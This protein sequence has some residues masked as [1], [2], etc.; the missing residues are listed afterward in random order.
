V[1]RVIYLFDNFQLDTSRRLLLHGEQ[2]LPLTARL[3]DTLIYLVEHAGSVVSKE[4]L[5]KA[6][7]PDA[8]VEENNLTQSIS[9]LRRVL[10]ERKGENRFIVTVAGHGYRFVAIASKRT[11]VAGNTSVSQR[12]IAVLPFKPLV[13]KHQDEALQLGMA[14]ALIIRLSSSREMIVRPLTSVRRFVSLDQDAQAAGRE[15]KVESVLDGNIQRAGDRVRVSARLIDV[16]DG[17]SLWAGTFDE[18]FTDVFSVQDAISERVAEALKLRLT[19]Q[20]RHGLTKRYTQNTAAYEL[21][22]QGRYHWN[23]LIPPEVW[24]AIGYFEQAIALDANYALAYTGM[25]VA[26]ISLPISCDVPPQEAFPRA[27]AAALE[28]LHIDESLHDAYAYLALSTCWFDW[29]SEAAETQIKRGLAI[30]PNSAELHR[31]YGILLSHT[32]RFNDAIAEGVRARELD[33]L[34]LITRVNEALHFYFARDHER[35]LGRI[36]QTLELEPTFWVALLT[37]ARIYVQQ[38]KLD[39][40]VSD[41]SKARDLCVGSTQPLAMLGQVFAL[42]GKRE[43]AKEILKQMHQ[44]ATQRYVPPYN[45]ALVHHGLGDDEQTFIWLERALEA[46]DVLLAA[47]IS[48]EPSWDQLRAERRFRRLLKRMNL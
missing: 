22:L 33:P 24:K 7:W 3:I 20:D 37:R 30:N 15:L 40:A 12:R 39:E 19:E 14:D 28:A 27:K 43:R 6:V 45:F 26:N 8:Y 2:T 4:E 11:T 48:T 38:G 21:Y 46:R 23:K 47:F 41:L 25:A 42:S 29:H 5:I 9:T 32:G 17:A 1:Q 16:N 35:A 13:E 34:S 44:L 10:G 18:P 36:E 31:V